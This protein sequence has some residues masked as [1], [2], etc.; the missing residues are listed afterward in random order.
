[1]GVDVELVVATPGGR[2]VEIACFRAESRV[3]GV[4]G[5]LVVGLA[6]P[7]ELPL[8]IVRAAVTIGRAAVVA[9]LESKEVD[10]SIAAFRERAVKIAPGKSEVRIGRVTDLV[11]VGAS[12]SAELPPAARRTTVAI[13]SIA[14][15]ALFIFVH[16]PIATSR[17][18]ATDLT[19]VAINR[20]A[21][22]TFLIQIL[23][24][25]TT[26][27]H[28]AVGFTRITIA[29]VVII[30]FFIPI[31][32]SIATTRNRAISLTVVAIEPVAI[33][34]AF[35]DRRIDEAVTACLVGLAVMRAAIT[36]ARVAI[37]AD[38][39]YLMDAITA[40]V[41]NDTHQLLNS[42]CL[43]P[44]QS[45]CAAHS[46]WTPSVIAGHTGR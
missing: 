5:L 20:I 39:A 46:N 40:S 18:P 45:K 31:Q 12:V 1:V 29:Q 42:T 19:A 21:I 8:A 14:I 27:R 17:K 33:V 2:A 11:V 38:F 3:G 44:I 26:T 9:L 32:N 13:A 37:V 16:D 30:A 25:V 4:A 24:S 15:I 34:A 6:V 22:V 43:I 7:T 36:I 35:A 41:W 23:D 10:L 28:R